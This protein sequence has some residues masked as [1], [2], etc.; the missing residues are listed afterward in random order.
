MKMKKN[1]LSVLRFPIAVWSV[2]GLGLVLLFTVLYIFTRP[3]INY[4]GSSFVIILFSTMIFIVLSVLLFLVTQRIVFDLNGI[5][6]KSFGHVIDCAEWIQ[7]H[8]ISV[9]IMGNGQRC[10]VITKQASEINTDSEPIICGYSTQVYDFIQNVLK[11]SP[12]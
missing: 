6:V 4:E 2:A 1:V 12:K 7:V 5:Y 9:S 8:D 3:Q 11:Q 10:I